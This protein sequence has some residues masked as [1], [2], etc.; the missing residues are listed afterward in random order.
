[1]LFIE[2]KTFKGI[3]MVLAGN[4]VGAGSRLIVLSL[5]ELSWRCR[6]NSRNH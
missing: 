3:L 1:M 5:G 6:G 4:D 2:K